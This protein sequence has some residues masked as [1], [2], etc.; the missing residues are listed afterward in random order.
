MQTCLSMTSALFFPIYR[1]LSRAQIAFWV[2]SLF[3]TDNRVVSVRMKRYGYPGPGPRERWNL[4][5]RLV[6]ALVSRYQGG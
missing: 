4:R 1:F 2:L 5:G 6:N 3:K